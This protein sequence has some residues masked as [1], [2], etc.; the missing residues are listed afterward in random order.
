MNREFLAEWRLKSLTPSLREA[1]ASW[2]VDRLRALDVGRTALGPRVETRQERDTRL[3]E[4]GTTI[5]SLRER[6]PY[7]LG[8]VGLG[9]LSNL[10]LASREAVSSAPHA[11]A[12][13]EWAPGDED[14]ASGPSLRSVVIEFDEDDP[15]P[16]FPCFLGIDPRCLL[17][18]SQTSTPPRVVAAALDGSESHLQALERI[19]PPG[20]V[21]VY[22]TLDGD[23][24]VFVTQDESLLSFVLGERNRE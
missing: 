11:E 16:L 10:P 3:E 6:L 17:R 23:A 14:F 18:F 4:I 2:R 13:V 8:V 5:R 22:P 9:A 7:C 20:T 1:S 21:A 19:L 15:G 24:V 12:G